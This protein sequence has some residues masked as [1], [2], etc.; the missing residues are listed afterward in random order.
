LL[1]PLLLC[2]YYSDLNRLAVDF[3]ELFSY[4]YRMARPPKDK[5]DRKDAELRIPVTEAQKAAIVQSAHEAGEDTAAWAR[6]ILLQAAH[7]SAVAG[8]H[9]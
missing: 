3:S 2:H 6:R 4:D 8:K 9:T 5:V 7:E 1:A